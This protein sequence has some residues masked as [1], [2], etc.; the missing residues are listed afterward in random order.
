MIKLP[1][2]KQDSLRLQRAIAQAIEQ[3]NVD[4]ARQVA[5]EHM[6]YVGCLLDDM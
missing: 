5:I 3:G 2:V 1:N 6:K 4:K